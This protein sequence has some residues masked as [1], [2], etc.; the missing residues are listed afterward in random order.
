MSDTTIEKTDEELSAY[1]ESLANTVPDT[2]PTDG[3]SGTTEEQI[4]EQSKEDV[5]EQIQESNNSE[6]I[7]VE[8]ANINLDENTSTDGSDDNKVTETLTDDDNINFEKALKE[9]GVT[10]LDKLHELNDSF[11]L[12]KLKNEKYEQ[13]DEQLHIIK[14]AKLSP[15]DLALATEAL[16]GNP[17]A[18]KKIMQLRELDPVDF[19][20]DEE[21]DSSEPIIDD[22]KYK[23]N[24]EEKIF[25]DALLVAESKGVGDT[26]MNAFNSWDENSLKDMMSNQNNVDLFIKE[27][28]DGSYEAIN[29]ILNEQ[30][31][32]DFSG[33]FS[34]KDSLDQYITAQQIYRD[35]QKSTE[36]EEVS[37]KKLP[38][39]DKEEVK[40]RIDVSNENKKLSEAKMASEQRGLSNSSTP[41][42]QNNVKSYSNVSDDDFF[43]M[44]DEK[45]K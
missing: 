20:T 26:F 18:L 35:R 21:D 30:L 4:T 34:K 38:T 39:T 24:D 36:T 22:S 12:N 6:D 19:I 29:D 31:R 14:E 16:K 17:D 27:L 42:E 1:L 9:I 5:E 7:K 3:T 37:S 2:V 40:N 13:F 23:V 33:S 15:T 44:F 43:K 11:R 8:D 45:F 10:S 41:A 32:Q 25:N 28:S